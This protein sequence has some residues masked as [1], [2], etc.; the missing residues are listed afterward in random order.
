MRRRVDETSVVAGLRDSLGALW[1]SEV[2]PELVY[3][4]LTHVPV[5]GDQGERRVAV[6]MQ[7][8]QIGFASR[9]QEIID[10]DRIRALAGDGGRPDEPRLAVGP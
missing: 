3:Q 6:Q 2:P 1:W 7:K 8:A 10:R 9:D 5:G 4:H